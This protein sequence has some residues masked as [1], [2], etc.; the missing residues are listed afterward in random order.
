MYDTVQILGSLIVLAAFIAALAGRLD[1][2][3]YRYLSMNAVGSIVLAAEAAIS[4]QWGF[5]ILESVWAIVSVY[6]I[7]RSWSRRRVR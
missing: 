6:S 1:Q 3:G 5:L 7:A 2:S 4:V